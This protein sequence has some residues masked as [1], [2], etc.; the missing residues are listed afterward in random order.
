VTLVYEVF[1][2]PDNTAKWLKGFLRFE[3]I[4][5]EPMTV[6]SKFRVILNNNGEIVTIIE[7]M[8]AI[9]NNKRFAFELESDVHL[10][11]TDITFTAF[12]SETTLVR[13]TNEVEAKT[14]LMRSIFVIMKPYFQTVSD[15]QF[16]TIKKLAE[17]SDVQ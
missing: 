15:K 17:S 13:S 11:H 2:N 7:T 8:T 1:T 6:G 3:V 10:G 16:A 4:D 5:G 14:A 12:D 9:E